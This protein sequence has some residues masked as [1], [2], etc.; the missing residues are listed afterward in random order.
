MRGQIYLHSSGL[1]RYPSRTFAGQ[2]V[3]QLESHVQRLMCL[4]IRAA[5][6]TGEIKHTVNE[7]RIASSRALREP[8]ELFLLRSVP[9]QSHMLCN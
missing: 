8:L 1:A 7:E 3:Y 9:Q 5:I 6:L 2:S 4:Q